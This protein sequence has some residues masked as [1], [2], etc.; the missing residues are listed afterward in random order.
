MK[1]VEKII[2]ELKQQSSD[3]YRMNVVRMGIPEN[4][5]IGVPTSDIRKL[6]KSIGVSQQLAIEL[7][8]KK[9]HEV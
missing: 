1:L 6:G 5:S 9:Y 8:K 2:T 4:Y 3:K 7:W